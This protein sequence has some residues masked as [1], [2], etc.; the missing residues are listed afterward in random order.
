MTSFEKFGENFQS[1]IIYHLVTDSDFAI[2]VLEILKPEFFSQ[3]NHRTIAQLIMRW[4]EKYGTIPSFEN[5]RTLLAK[6]YKEDEILSEYMTSLVSDIEFKTNLLDK[7]HVIDETVEFCK[8]QAFRNAIFESV[9]LVKKEKY[10]EIYSIFQKAMVAGEKKNIGH[11]YFHDMNK[12]VMERRFPIATGFQMLDPVIS[13]GLSGGELGLIL[14]GTGIGKSMI[15]VHLAAEAYKQGKKVLYYTLELS[16]KIV[17]LRIDS[18]IAGIPLSSLL[19]DI[20]GGLRNRIKNEITKERNKH[21]IKPELIIKNFPTKTASIQTLNNHLR[22]LENK[23]FI[24]DII[25]VDYVDLLRPTNRYGDKRFELESLTE[26]LRGMAGTRDIPLWSASQTNRE[27][28]DTSIVGL[29]TISES[30]AKAFVADLVISIGRS[31]ALVDEGRACYYIAKSRLGPDKLPFT[32]EFDT[33]L[34]NFT[35]DSEGFDEEE[36]R[37]QDRRFAMNR[38]VERV[39]S[40]APTETSNNNLNEILRT[41]DM[42]IS[43]GDTE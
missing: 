34:V 2:Q 33:S 1:K 37:E 41:L 3:E 38:A 43:N 11:D 12:R 36:L 20:D 19:T 29:K 35:I 23:G 14:A 26:E 40:Q 42:N 10:D 16:E 5:L 6:L 22:M 4:N 21:Q 25:F 39:Q 7:A 27:G 28:W 9:E 32:G 8:Q 24:P 15:L 18:K 30:A 13:G 31:Q 17:G